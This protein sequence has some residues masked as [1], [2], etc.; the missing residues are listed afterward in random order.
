[1][2]DLSQFVR[3]Y[4]PVLSL[5]N[6]LPE[7]EQVFVPVAGSRWGTTSNFEYVT[8]LGDQER[9]PDEPTVQVEDNNEYIKRHGSEVTDPVHDNKGNQLAVGYDFVCYCGAST[10]R[11]VESK[12]SGSVTVKKR[13]TEVTYVYVDAKPLMKYLG[14]ITEQWIQEGYLESR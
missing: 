1:M 8:E 4:I 3:R 7:R 10:R 2:T 5:A 9:E 12:K 14:N 13:V 11:F 6:E